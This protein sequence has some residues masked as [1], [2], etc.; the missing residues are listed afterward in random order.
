M[1]ERRRSV[2]NHTRLVDAMWET[3][4][5]WGGKRKKCRKEKAGPVAVNPDDLANNKEEEGGA[6]GTQGSSKNRTSRES[7]SPLSRLISGLRNK[8]H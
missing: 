8:Y 4:E 5:T 3:G 6:Q 7:V 1:E 2:R